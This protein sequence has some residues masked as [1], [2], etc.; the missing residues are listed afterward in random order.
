MGTPGGIVAPFQQQ[1]FPQAGNAP[2]QLPHRR[3]RLRLAHPLKFEGC[4]RAQFAGDDDRKGKAGTLAVEGHLGT[5]VI[6]LCNAA[7]L[8]SRKFDDAGE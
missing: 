5:G 1:V 7:L 6:V 4:D 8:F 2:L 3:A